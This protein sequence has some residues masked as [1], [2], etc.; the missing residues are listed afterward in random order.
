MT[1][2]AAP[3]FLSRVHLPFLPTS[4]EPN[5]KSMLSM[6]SQYL[7]KQHLHTQP[8][9]QD[10][11]LSVHGAAWHTPHTLITCGDAIPLPE[12]AEATEGAEAH[13]LRLSLTPV[14][15]A[16]AQIGS[17]GTVICKTNNNNAHERQ[18]HIKSD[19]NY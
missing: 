12:P 16:S 1:V 19:L 15:P 14:R 18:G 10:V 13:T 2:T 8:G 4:M 6:D 11:R 9:S 3:L 17:L 7:I 5:Q